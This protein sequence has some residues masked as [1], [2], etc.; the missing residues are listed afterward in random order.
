MPH[1]DQ[2]RYG[3]LRARERGASW[4]S[5][6][7]PAGAG[8]VSRQRGREAR[9]TGH[10]VAPG[11]LERHGHSSRVDDTASSSSSAFPRLP[12]LPKRAPGP[13]IP[14]G[15]R[16]PLHIPCGYPRNIQFSVSWG[17]VEAGARFRTRSRTHRASDGRPGLTRRGKL[18]T[19][20]VLLAFAAFLLWS[21]LASQ[22][23]ECTVSVTFGNSQGS[24]RASAATEADA[25]QQAQ[26]AA[27]GPLTGGMNERIACSRTPPMI[28]RC[29]S[30]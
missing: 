15:V 9:Y 29:R 27:C 17:T 19:L 28:R 13:D 26:T 14:R 18:L 22:H 11:A 5:G 30:L 16:L 12:P 7:K 10:A 1:P 6:A 23:V 20:L 24:G 21:T 8:I 3:L 4:V 25:L 2:A